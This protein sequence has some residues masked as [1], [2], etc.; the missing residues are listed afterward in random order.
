MMMI[1]HSTISR[2]FLFMA[3]LS[4][5]PS[6]GAPIDL[7]AEIKKH[8]NVP[9]PCSCSDQ[10][11]TDL[12]S[13][14]K[15][16]E[17]AIK[18]YESL[19]KEWETKEKGAKESLLLTHDNRSSV[20]GSVGFRMSGVRTSNARS[21]GADTDPAC[22]TTIDADATPCLRGA[23]EDHESVHKKACDANKSANPFVDW[24]GKQR[25]VDYMREEQAGYRKELE[26]LKAE[27][28]KMKPFCSLDPSVQKALR[29]IAAEKER[30]AEAHPRVKRVADA[31]K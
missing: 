21:F 15:Q 6:M 28:D 5:P 18:E 10:D 16:V 13:R 4:P 26:R 1:W 20:Q 31:T 2:L 23:L 14:I 30:Q 3:L 27:L 22:A 7:A 9:V 8:L 25:V 29:S 12:E 24:R 11:K 17:A 19:I